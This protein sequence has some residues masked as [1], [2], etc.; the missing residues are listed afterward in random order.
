[1]KDYSSLIA[2]GR[3]RTDANRA[4]CKRQIT[5]ISEQRMVEEFSAHRPN[6]ALDEWT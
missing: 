3:Q 6:Q 4:M 1:M 2:L 5:S